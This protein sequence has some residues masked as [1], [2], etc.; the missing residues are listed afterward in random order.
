MSNHTVDNTISENNSNDRLVDK[1]RA[2]PFLK[3][4]RI[5]QHRRDDSGAV[6]RWVA[7]HSSDDQR[8]LRL[9]LHQL[10]RI[11][12]YE[13]Y[14]TDSF[15]V[16]SEVLGEALRADK[17]DSALGEHPYGVRVFVQI[18]A[19]EALLRFEV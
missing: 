16:Q 3:E 18:T 9:G 4:L 12:H 11:S 7:V 5:L 14:V 8:Q 13:N 10:L 15:V 2:I 17:L 6:T 19:R 1:M